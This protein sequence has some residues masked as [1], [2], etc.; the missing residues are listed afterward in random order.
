[1]TMQSQPGTESRARTALLDAPPRASRARAAVT[2]RLLE[3]VARR[4]P[5]DIVLPDGSLLGRARGTRP[6]AD[7][8]RA[9]ILRP[10]VLLDRM[11][12][13]PK[14]AFGEGY[15]AGD[16][17]PATGTDL[18]AV[19]LPFAE[20]QR[21]LLPAGMSR[22]R[23]LVS[24]RPPRAER[25]SPAGA[26]RN[27][28]AH[29]D[30]SNDLFAAFL[31]ATLTYSSARFDDALPWAE[32]TLEQAQLRKVNSIL[33]MAGVRE[34]SQVLEIGTGWGTLAI[35]AAR[36]RAHVTTLTLSA[37]QAALAARRVAAA[38]VSD[39]VE[40]RLQDYREVQGTFDS[41]V[42]VEMIEAVGEEFWPDYFS[43]LDQRL[44]PGGVAAIQAI[45]V[46]HDR[47]LATRNSYSWVQKHIFPGG[48]VP[49]L[50]AIE[51]TAEQH[52]TLRVVQVDRFGRHYAETLRRWRAT[53]N[54]SWDVI[55][56]YGF[57]ETFRR[58]WEYYL[59]GAEAG[60]D[61][62]YLDVAQIRLERPR[63]VGTA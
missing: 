31:D 15:M 7:R 40:I 41:I 30:L 59:A 8:P 38:G 23:R 36:R 22:L 19:L 43:V 6:S 12:S 17:R 14:M 61:A 47:L 13:E 52:T 16:W 55:A 2:W 20:R 27:I 51:E 63:Q 56:G 1:M 45:L 33:D 18:A 35:E 42:S 39:R 24:A 34:G 4:V 10:D 32:Q 11:S 57:D 54:D 28:A 29:Y 37:E 26:R 21:A 58:M 62:D 9:E 53:F 25:N 50:R 3:Q 5:V 60:F 44:A 46:P 49:S 48:I